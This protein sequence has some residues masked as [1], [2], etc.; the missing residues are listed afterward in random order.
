MKRTVQSWARCQIFR[1]RE[2]LGIP[3]RPF[4][5]GHFLILAHSESPFIFG[6][7]IGD[8]D[9]IF[10]VNICS[11]TYEQCLEWI[12]WRDFESEA[13]D[14]FVKKDVTHD[15]Y[16]QALEFFRD[17]LT[18]ALHPPPYVATNDGDPTRAGAPW[19]QTMKVSLMKNLHMTESQILDQWL[20]KS[21]YDWFSI[22]EQNDPKK[23]RLKNE[24]DFDADEMPTLTKEQ[25]MDCV[26]RGM[27]VDDYIQKL[28]EGTLDSGNG[29]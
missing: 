9:F 11:R 27:A 28:K 4:S 24:S 19:V 13:T 10:A 2:V 14:D 26:Q 6:G 22:L 8:G 12:Y 29:D 3:L 1:P 20:L 5:L 7:P 25:M 17:Y 15:Q 16:E 23:F 21:Q 18:E